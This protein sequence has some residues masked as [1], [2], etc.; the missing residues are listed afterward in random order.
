MSTTWSCPMHPEIESNRAGD[1]PKCGMALERIVVA[2]PPQ[3]YTCPMHPEIMRN[4]PGDCPIC[5]MALEPVLVTEDEEENHELIDMTRRF[6]VSLIFTLPVFFIAM[7][8]L[9][10]GQPVSAVL[11]DAVRPWFEL[12][13]AS[14]VVLWGAS[15]FFV[16][17]WRSIVT[18]N[19]NIFPDS[20]WTGHAVA[21][22]YCIV[23]SPP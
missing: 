10:P 6:R 13:L 20:R 14:P 1:C 7:G 15:P 4:E 21:A 17:G 3:Q 16:R 12:L 22:P 9:L 11:S 5:G 19:L 8:D 23:L 2:V 18:R